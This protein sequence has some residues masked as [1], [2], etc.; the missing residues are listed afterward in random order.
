MV[1]INA[2]ISK[3]SYTEEAEMAPAIISGEYKW[4]ACRASGEQGVTAEALLHP[5]ACPGCWSGPGCAAGTLGTLLRSE[6][7]TVIRLSRLLSPKSVWGIGGLGCGRG[8]CCGFRSTVSGFAICCIQGLELN[9]YKYQYCFWACLSCCLEYLVCL[10]MA[11]EVALAS[12]DSKC[13]GLVLHCHTGS[14]QL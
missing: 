7:P 6:H 8:R 3:L 10:N 14:H 2:I 13:Q 9:S 1:A 12:C 5:G 11:K 4:N